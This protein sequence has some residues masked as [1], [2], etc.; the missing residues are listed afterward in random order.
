MKAAE[1]TRPP[2]TLTGR[3]NRVQSIAMRITGKTPALGQTFPCNL[4][5]PRV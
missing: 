3:K 2:F 4:L 1:L 5:F